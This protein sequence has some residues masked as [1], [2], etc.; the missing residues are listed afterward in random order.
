MAVA[1]EAKPAS[2]GSSEEE[3]FSSSREMV[4][5]EAG[6]YLSPGKG[7]DGN[8]DI[9]GSGKVAAAAVATAEEERKEKDKVKII[10]ATE[11]AWYLS[12]K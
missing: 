7:A 9:E 2:S 11:D 10:G 12:S 6:E 5:P 4:S 1:G 8:A 3:Y